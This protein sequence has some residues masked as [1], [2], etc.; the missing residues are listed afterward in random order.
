VESNEP[1]GTPTITGPT[2]GRAGMEY[3]HWFK[4]I[5]PDRNP[6]HLYIEWGDGT[7]TGWIEEAASGEEVVI[8]HTWSEKGNY[9]IRCKA[10]DV[11]DK[12]SDWATF[13]VKIERKSREVQQMLFYRLLEQ[14]PLI[15]RFIPRITNP[16]R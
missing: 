4:A 1:P 7:N 3:D 2:I 10:K 14:F 9:I 15:G 11:F 5:D 6:M 8:E 16:L 13:E 12:E